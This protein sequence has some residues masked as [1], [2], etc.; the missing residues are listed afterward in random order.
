ML[1]FVLARK[2]YA[3]NL[4]FRSA[5]LVH[6]IA[7]AIFGFIYISIWTGIGSDSSL[8]EYGVA[9]MATY[10]AFNQA[11]LWLSAFA[12]N[13][14]GLEQS[15]RTGQIAIE[16]MRP[17]N[18][19]YHLM[20]KEWGNLFYQFFYKSVPIYLLYWL[21]LPLQVPTSVATWGWTAVA[22]LFAAYITI[23]L[24]FLIGA[25]AM[26]TTESRWLY[27][28]NYAFSTLLSG[29]LIPIEWLPQWLHFISMHSFYP[30]LLYIPSR[31]HLGMESPL[32]LLGALWWALGFTIACLLA[33]KLMRRHVEV[34]GG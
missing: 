31:M 13:G 21:V 9:G 25:A 8:G 27:W 2:T 32:A 4:Q 17:A 20:A 12:T 24:N 33:L 22:L 5:H 11:S 34:Q 26:L 30:Y 7:S 14:L 18:L 19:Y 28:L 6:N 1:F 16:L 15:V 23:A 29:F 3:R 10:V